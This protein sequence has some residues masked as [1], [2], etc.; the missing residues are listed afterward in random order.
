MS[1]FGRLFGSNP[2]ESC[3]EGLAALDRRDFE[4]ATRAFTTCLESSNRESTVRLA[5]FHLAE[6]HTQLAESAWTRGEYARARD[7]IEVALSYAHPT[8]ERHLIAAQIARRIDDRADAAYHLEAALQRSPGHE[9]ALALQAL[10]WYEE[11]RVE[12]ALANAEALLLIDGRAA[13]FREAH[14]RGDKDAAKAHLL[15]VAT[16]F[17]QS[18]VQPRR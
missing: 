12:G 2:E 8:A 14:A 7:E 15:A 13:R 6:C 3:E 9:Q 1:F 16:G 4:S 17:P 5:R 10:G 18:L 11:G